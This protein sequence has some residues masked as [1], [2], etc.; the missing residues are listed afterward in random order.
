MDLVSVCLLVALMMTVAIG[1]L[2]DV[3]LEDV[4][5]ACKIVTATMFLLL[6]TAIM[7]F[8]EIV[9]AD[10]RMGSIVITISVQCAE[11]LMMQVAIEFYP[12]A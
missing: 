4:S 12:H 10:A 8:V 7:V 11:I 2:P 6:C 5:H 9:M 3:I 1:Q